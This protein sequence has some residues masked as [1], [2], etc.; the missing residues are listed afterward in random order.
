MLIEDETLTLRRLC[1]ADLQAFQSYRLDPVVGAYQDWNKMTDAQARAFLEAVS[2]APLFVPGEW[3]QIA[4]VADGLVGD[5]GLCLDPKGQEVEIGI[6]LARGAQGLGYGRRAMRLAVQLVW[7]DSPARCIRAITD[8][9]NTAPL[10]LLERS[11]FRE[12]LP[13]MTDG[14]AERQFTLQRPNLP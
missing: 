6:T 5:I 10:V 7:R 3:S 4:V 9:R 8:A 14:L 11:G 13:L 2:S 1:V 12:G